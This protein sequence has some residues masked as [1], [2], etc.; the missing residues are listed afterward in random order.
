M[1]FTPNDIVTVKLTEEGRR[2]AVAATDA[3]NEIFKRYRNLSHRRAIPFDD[4][5][6]MRGQFWCMI[7]NIG[8]FHGG[9]GQDTLFEWIEYEPKDKV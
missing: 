3:I 2:R 4:A 1:R 6:I 8:G 9:A 7:D 5:G